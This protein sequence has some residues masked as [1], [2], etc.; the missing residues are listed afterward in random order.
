M[1]KFIA[2]ISTAALL[3]SLTACGETASSVNSNS[4]STTS[5]TNSG[6][7]DTVSST[8]TS[9]DESQTSK[10]EIEEVAYTLGGELTEKMIS[11]S[12][13]NE[14]NKVRLANVIK[15]LQNKEEV[16]IAF[17]GGSITQGTSAG[18]ELC[19][20]NLISEWFKAKYPDAKINYINAGIGATGS[21]IG[22]HR[23]NDDVLSKNPDLVFV[24]FSVNDTTENTERNKIAYDSLLQQIW[25]YETN[26]AIITIAMTM[27]N[28]TSFQQYHEEIVKAYDLPMISYKNTILDVIEKGYIK[29]ADISDDDI[30]PNVPGHAIL[31]QLVESYI[32]DVIDSLD[33]ISGAE[34][35]LSK[36]ATSIYKNAELIRPIKTTPASMEGFELRDINFGNFQ[37]IWFARAGK[38]DFAGAKLSFEVTGKSFGILYG[39]LTS[40]GTTADIYVDGEKVTTID[41]TFANG[42]GNYVECAEIATFDTDA[43]HTIDIC[44]TNKTD[45]SAAMFYVSAIAISH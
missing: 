44:P 22:V 45:G 8:D 37:G 28:G 17:I 14:G 19:Y 36:P 16:T 3:V 39:K 41:G 32:T 23:V 27:E 38:G 7:S 33:T 30:H 5:T 34:S 2:L 25:A 42:W 43:A 6:S 12:R 40:K 9:A 20:A 26:P 10:E 4:T 18:N 11:E 31:A 29:W 15:K 1:K 24:E 35:D 21:Y 13:L